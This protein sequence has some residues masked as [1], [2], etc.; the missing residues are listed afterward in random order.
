LQ[1]SPASISRDDKRRCFNKVLSVTNELAALQFLSSML[2]ATVSSRITT[3]TEDEELLAV[4]TSNKDSE[5]EIDLGGE[6]QGTKC[7]LGGSIFGLKE[8]GSVSRG[9]EQDSVHG[10]K[11]QDSVFGGKEQGSVFGGKERGS[12]LDV[13]DEVSVKGT[14]DNKSGGVLEPDVKSKERDLKEGGSDKKRAGGVEEDEKWKLQC[15]VTYRLTRKHIVDTNLYKLKV[16]MTFLSDRQTEVR[17]GDGR[18][19]DLRFRSLSVSEE[20]PF[21]PLITEKR[22]SEMDKDSKPERKI[23]ADKI[24]FVNAKDESSDIS[25]KAK[26]TSNNNLKMTN[27]ERDSSSVKAD[28]DLYIKQVNNRNL[29]SQITNIP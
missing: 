27:S 21:V 11:E 2:A 23:S 10:G 8:L 15:A 14:K 26:F 18:P 3:T 19:D 25:L 29:S 17:Y 22:D 4:I 5:K 20:C 13:V 24:G 9:K 1:R 28:L 6:S 16:I 12:K 7:E